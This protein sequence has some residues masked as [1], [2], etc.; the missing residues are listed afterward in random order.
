MEARIPQKTTTN[1][2]KAKAKTI[3]TK[4]QVKRNDIQKIKR[5]AMHGVIMIMPT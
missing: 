2:Q 5:I 4:V 3:S 1:N